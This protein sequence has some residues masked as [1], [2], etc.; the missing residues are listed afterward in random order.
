MVDQYGG[1]EA[2]GREL[3][4][5]VREATGLTVSV[6]VG[7]NKL[8]AKIASDRGKP[9]G[10]LVVPPGQERAFLSPLPLRALWGIGP[11]TGALLQALGITTCG[12]LAQ[13]DPQVLE[14]RLG[15]R[16]RLFHEL[17]N[18]IDERPLETER[19]RKS[20]G[21]E[22]TFPRDLNP[23]ESQQF[24]DELLHLAQEVQRRLRAEGVRGRTITIKLR[25]AN[26]RTI[27][28]Q[29]TLPAPTDDP[30]VI[31][32]MALALFEKVH[33]SGDTF[34]LAGIHVSHL[35]PAGQEQLPLWA[36]G[37]QGAKA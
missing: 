2:L 21:A 18:G 10:L 26:F 6:G 35:T 8:V 36:G 32:Q 13:A 25:Y 19:E 33:R 12:E 34:R 28:R 9:D 1:P 3:K 23:E 7:P 22:T 4:R 37:V 20:V 11:K 14:A 30:S 15:S 24:R 31:Y 17:A 5:R 27:T 29:T 16:G